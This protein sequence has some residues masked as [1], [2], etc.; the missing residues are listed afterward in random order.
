[1]AS[2][3]A[4]ATGL[5]H[6][7]T[8]ADGLPAAKIQCLLQT[9]DGSLWVGTRSALLRLMA[10]GPEG[11]VRNWPC[12]SRPTHKVTRTDSQLRLPA[13][14][15]DSLRL[16]SIATPL[17]PSERVRFQYRLLGRDRQWSELGVQRFVSSQDL[18]PGHYAFHVTACTRHGVWNATG[19][20]LALCGTPFFYQTWSFYGLCAVALALAAAAVLTYRLR[21]QRRILRLERENA[22]QHERARIAKDLHD[23]LGARLTQLGL[24]CGDVPPT[25]VA[26]ALTQASGLVRDLARSLDE[27]VWAVT[28]ANDRLEPFAGYVV[29]YAQEFLARTP[30]ALRLDLPPSLPDLPLRAEVRH[31]LLM[32]LKE[33]LTNVVKHAHATTV[34]VKLWLEND[35][36]RLKL[37]D[38][39]CGFD[40]NQSHANRNGL[41]YLRQR[42]ESLGGWAAI[43]SVSGRGTEVELAVPLRPPGADRR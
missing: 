19:A 10:L 42:L 27:I 41:R 8:S 16:R 38:D 18:P 32:A 12:S 33:S 22:L 17:V 14:R 9:R 11:P 39:G 21:L 23:E 7:W 20:N 2:T 28:P 26:G 24:V 25:S 30:V 15:G 5:F 43:R 13:G 4:F 1:M 6:Q 34:R 3:N 37:T 35:H 29:S 31:N 40:P 36:L